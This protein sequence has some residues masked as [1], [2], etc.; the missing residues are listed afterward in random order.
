MLLFNT[1]LQKHE[2]V[3]FRNSVLRAWG[4]EYRQHGEKVKTT[5]ETDSLSLCSMR[6]RLCG[7]VCVCVLH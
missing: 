7:C 4:G 5:D 2:V 6:M 1:L 3:L